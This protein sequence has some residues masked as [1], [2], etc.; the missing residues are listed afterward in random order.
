MNPSLK[1]IATS[2]VEWEERAAEVSDLGVTAF[3]QKP[4]T[5]E[6]LLGVV[7]QVLKG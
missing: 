2:G 5:W 6:R 3:L 4:F 1:V 7:A